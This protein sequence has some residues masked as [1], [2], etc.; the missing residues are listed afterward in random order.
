[1]WHPA[2]KEDGE[3]PEKAHRS[4]SRSKVRLE[5]SAEAGLVEELVEVLALHAGLEFY[6]LA[7]LALALVGCLVRRNWRRL[8]VVLLLLT[9]VYFLVLSGGPAAY[10]RFRLPLVPMFSILA[11]AGWGRLR[12]FT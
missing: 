12:R 4:N 9:L 3:K 1:M 8:V 7:T 2:R 10:H 6:L 11:A 5:V